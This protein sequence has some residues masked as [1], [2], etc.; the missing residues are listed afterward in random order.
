M[1]A[2]TLS[3]AAPSFADQDRDEDTPYIDVARS[4]AENTAVGRPIGRHVSATDADDDIPFY[5]LLDTPDLEDDDGDARFTIDSLVRSDY[6]RE[7]AGC[8]PRGD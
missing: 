1:E 4:V 8:G 6:G 3:N 2:K 5:E 7:G